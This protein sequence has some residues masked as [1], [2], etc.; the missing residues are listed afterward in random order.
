MSNTTTR[1]VLV[2]RADETQPYGNPRRIHPADLTSERRSYAI[3]NYQ[4]GWRK[5]DIQPLS[6]WQR[7]LAEQAE[8]TLPTGPN[9]TRK[10]R[11]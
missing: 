8:T 9:T 4:L 1:Y 5:Y 2:T 11:Q 7:V 3:L 10:T 6:L